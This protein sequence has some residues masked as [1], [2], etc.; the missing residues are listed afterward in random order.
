M[1]NAPA[2][3][4]KQIPPE[5]ADRLLGDLRVINR[6]LWSLV[7]GSPCEAGAVFAEPAR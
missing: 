6:L 7:F 5:T 4:Q 2:E 1:R 3:R